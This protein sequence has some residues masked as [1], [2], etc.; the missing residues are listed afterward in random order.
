MEKDLMIQVLQEMESHP[1]W[2]L[3]LAHLDKL[4][5]I[6]EVEK[7]QALRSEHPFQAARKQ[8][9]IDGIE[10]SKKGLDVLITGLQSLQEG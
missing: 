7:S 6:R 10:L 5:R 2:K 1:A 3:Y 9:E 4:C 8:F